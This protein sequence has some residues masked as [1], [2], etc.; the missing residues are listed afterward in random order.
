MTTSTT[1]TVCGSPSKMGHPL[2]T[3]KSDQIETPNLSVS[4]SPTSTLTRQQQQ[5]GQDSSLASS[6]HNNKTT[7]VLCPPSRTYCF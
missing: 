1:V 2:R 7:V 4:S 3:L 5:K 6:E